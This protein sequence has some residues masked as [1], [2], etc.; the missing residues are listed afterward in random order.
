[1]YNQQKTQRNLFVITYL[2]MKQGDTPISIR[3]DGVVK[4]DRLK[5]AKLDSDN[6]PSTVQTLGVMSRSTL[7]V[8]KNGQAAPRIVGDPN[9]T[10]LLWPFERA[11]GAR[12]PFA[13]TR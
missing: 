11:I 5:I 3:Y 4:T 9:K 8:F 12:G 6:N 2:R 10:Q 7:L 13:H 1:M